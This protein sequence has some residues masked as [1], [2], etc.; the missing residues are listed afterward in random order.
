MKEAI[1]KY[2]DSKTLELLKSLAKYFDFSIAEK[3]EG[4]A[5]GK[6]KVSFTALRID[7]RGYKFNRDEANER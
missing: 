7:T 3:K 1:I 6:K 2:K 4:S 5:N